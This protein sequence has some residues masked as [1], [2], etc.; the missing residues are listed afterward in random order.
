VLI[1]SNVAGQLLF[2]LDD[3]DARAELGKAE[4]QAAMAAVRR[5][6][7]HAPVLLGSTFVAMGVP[8]MVPTLATSLRSG[9]PH[10]MQVRSSRPRRRRARQ[11]Q[12]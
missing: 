12:C 4:A 3:N 11:P 5:D 8:A 7:E 10:A 2:T 1:D 9:V 6:Y